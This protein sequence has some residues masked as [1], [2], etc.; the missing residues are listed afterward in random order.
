M[1]DESGCLLFSIVGLGF[2][3]AVIA[4]KLFLIWAFISCGVSMVKTLNDHC[5]DEYKIESV[6]SGDW[7]CPSDASD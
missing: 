5:G 4:L 1:R 7:F 2:T 3:L 6:F